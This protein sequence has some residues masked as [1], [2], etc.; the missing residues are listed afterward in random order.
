VQHW[1][2]YYRNETL[3]NSS[4]IARTPYTFRAR[5]INLSGVEVN[6]NFNLTDYNVTDVNYGFFSYLGSLVDKITKLFVIDINANGS[7]NISGNLIVGTDTLFVNATSG[8]VG[9]G[10]TSPGEKLHVG[11][12]TTNDNVSVLIETQNAGTNI[13]ALKYAWGGTEV[14]WIKMPFDTRATLGLEINTKAYPISFR[15]NADTNANPTLFLDTDGDVGI[16]TASPDEKLQVVGNVMIGETDTTGG[17]LELWGTTAGKYSEIKTT[18]GNLHIDADNSGAYPI[19]LNYYGGT[20]GVNFGSGAS[21]TVASVS[22]AGVVNANGGLSQDGNVILNGADTW[23][24]TT[25][26]TGWYSQTHGGGWYMTDAS[27]VRTY[28]NK[29]I[30]VSGTGSSYFAGKVGIGATTP[31][32]KLHLS[33]IGAQTGIL[34]DRT[35]GQPSIKAGS[36][37]GYMMIDSAGQKLG[38]NWYVADDVILAN[39][40]G[41]VGIGTTSPTFLF[42][43]EDT[44]TVNAVNLAG[45]LLI[46]SINN[47]VSI[48][49]VPSTPIYP[50]MRMDSA[51]G[52][53]FIDT[54]LR[55][56]KLDISEIPQDYNYSKLLDITP[57]KWIDKETGAE[58]TGLIAEDMEELG[59]KELLIYDSAGNLAGVRYE[60]I[61][62]LLIPII[63]NL[64]LENRVLK[65]ENTQIKAELCQ[66]DK[67]YS[68]CK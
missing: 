55:K 37:D 12:A 20:G 41:N 64:F 1:L 49:E 2:C 48:K 23:V 19:Y 28:N 30:Y 22:S 52:T 57:K 14:G 4:K 26:S 35:S 47:L 60:T 53:I 9:I 54:S 36:D 7:A 58:A 39:G 43:V 21:S 6:S 18:S 10:T 66:K 16:G 67:T 51:S 8:N 33:S 63:K 62:V 65:L 59:I 29:P 11:S 56:Y 25:G 31:G 34:I 32:A 45:V 50:V 40:G 13:P 46:D 44:A 61:G 42:E 68:W 38:L 24:R 15:P 27:Y 17:T 3:I 5:N